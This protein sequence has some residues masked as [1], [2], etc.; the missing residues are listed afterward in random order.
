MEENNHYEKKEDTLDEITN[1]ENIDVNKENLN[2][3][4]IEEKE[5]ERKKDITFLIIIGMIIVIFIFL[6][7]TIYKKLNPTTVTK[8]SKEPE[9]TEEKVTN[10][11]YTCASTEENPEEGYEISKNT[12][13]ILVK[14]QMDSIKIN[15]SY[16]F[17]EE[18]K[19]RVFKEQKQLEENS[20]GEFDDVNLSYFYIVTFDK[21][22]LQNKKDYPLTKEELLKLIDEKKM[23]CS[24]TEN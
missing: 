19:Y 23:S 24:V 1:N 8:P 12:T 20:I 15:D 17:E 10:K 3:E 13:Y 9:K 7:P 22:E 4:S 2:Q 16:S 14:D 21:K 6:M 11:T 5:E 18:E